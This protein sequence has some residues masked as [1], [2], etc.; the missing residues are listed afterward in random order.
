MNEDFLL[1]RLAERSDQAAFRQLRL[2][3]DKID[4][5]SNDYLGIVKRELLRETK[6]RDAESAKRW[7]GATGS[8]L[9]SGNYSY[10]EETEDFIAGFHEAPRGLL[11]N[12]GYDAN[13]GLLSAVPQRGD[14]IIYDQLCHASIRDGLRLSF[15]QSHSFIHNDISDLK[16]KLRRGSG[17]LFVVTESVFSMDGHLAPLKEIFTICEEFNANLI[18]DEAHATGVVGERGEGLAQQLGIH[19]KCFARVHTFG[20]ALGCHGAIV[21]GTDTL[22]NYLINF[23]RPF[24]YTTAIPSVNVNAARNSYE[25]FP[26]M[27]KERSQL[28]DLVRI[29]QTELFTSGAGSEKIQVLNSPTPIQAVILPGNEHVK[30]LSNT[31]AEHGFDARP[32]LYPTV[33]KGKERLR[34][35]LHS[36]NTVD[37]LMNLI[38]VIKN[39]D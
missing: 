18:V 13:L 38:D 8:R 4:F 3:N 12:S 10:I 30:N 33:P 1:K 7:H 35:V 31:L 2:P 6:L 24:I 39:S 20:K 14:T 26:S 36:F 29:F 17:T 23:S 19:S 11:Y 16:E 25:I 22:R 27:R 9:L 37:Q 21:L 28:A 32:I 34:I 5:S 15:A